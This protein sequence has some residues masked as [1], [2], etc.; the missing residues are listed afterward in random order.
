MRFFLFALIFLGNFLAANSSLYAEEPLKI[1]GILAIA[2]MTGACGILNSM[3]HFQKTTQMPGG[4]DFIV[5]FWSTEATRLG[6]S[7]DQ[8][9]ENCNSSIST[10]DRMIEGFD[11]LDTEGQHEGK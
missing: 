8:Y 2:K 6:M 3:T 5:R 9:I 4:N 7:E 11:K 10:Y 1:Q